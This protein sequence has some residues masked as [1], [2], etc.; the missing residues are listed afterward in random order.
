[1]IDRRG[2]GGTNSVFSRNV[3]RLSLLACALHTDGMPDIDV[4]KKSLGPVADKYTD[5]ELQQL[6]LDIQFLAELLLDIYMDGRNRGKM[7]DPAVF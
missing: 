1:V 3:R 6:Q 5:A 4:F 2:C 7:D